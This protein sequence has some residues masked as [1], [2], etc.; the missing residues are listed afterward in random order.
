MPRLSSFSSRFLA[1]IGVAGIQL[2]LPEFYY[3][4]TNTSTDPTSANWRNNYA[5]AG[6]TFVPN[7]GIYTEGPITN[8]REMFSSDGSLQF[9]DPDIS[10]WDVSTVTNMLSMFFSLQTLTQSLNSWDVSNV[11]NMGSMFRATFNYNQPLNNWNV[12]NVTNMSGMFDSTGFNQDISMWDVGSV[13]NMGAMFAFSSFNQPIGSWDV[14]NV[15]NMENMFLGNNSFAQ[16]LSSWC[17]TNI[18]EEP[19]DFNNTNGVN[20]VWGT[21]PDPLELWVYR[22][23]LSTTAFGSSYVSK[24][25]WNG[26]IF[27]VGGDAG[28]IATSTD[29]KTWTYRNGLSQT[30]WGNIPVWDIIYDSGVFWAGGGGPGAVASSPDGINWTYRAEL[31]PLDNPPGAIVI[32][33]KSPN[34]FVGIGNFYRVANSTNGITWNTGNVTYTNSTSTLQILR[35]VMWSGQRFIA[36][37]EFGL[38]M[39]SGNGTS[40]TYN[41]S[42]V[43]QASLSL[44][45]VAGNSGTIVAVSEYGGIVRSTDHGLN[46]TIVNENISGRQVVFANGLFWIAGNNTVVTSPDGINWTY[47]SENISQITPSN[48]YCNNIAVNS[49]TA[50]VGSYASNGAIATYRIT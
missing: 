35:G 38:I 15:T 40:W 17:V 18:T 29:G 24:I 8:M 31:W 32:L 6:Y 9:N 47:V 13:T 46:W 44:A 50:V 4:L 22:E 48:S 16:D 41:D 1:G 19:F 23:G 21:C 25:L 14:S 20:P 45:S 27:I 37:G 30:A 26:S 7:N 11:T 42:L 2:Q 5:P 36:V 10:T 34:I 3:P 43:S 28:K 12:S 33:A 39:T 49:T